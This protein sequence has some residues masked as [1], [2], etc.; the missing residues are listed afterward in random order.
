M[1][2]SEQREQVLNDYCKNVCTKALSECK[3]C[4]MNYNYPKEYKY[5]KS[6]NPP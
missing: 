1:T 3:D 4:S 2:V 5:K 6:E